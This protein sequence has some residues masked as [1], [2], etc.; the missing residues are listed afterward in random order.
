MLTPTFL[1]FELVSDLQQAFMQEIGGGDP[2][3]IPQRIEAGPPGGDQGQ[4]G[5]GGAP[6]RKL[7]P[8]N[9]PAGGAPAPWQS[10]G[11][12]RGGFGGREAAPSSGPAPWHRPAEGGGERYGGGGGYGQRTDGYG[13]GQ[14]AGG[15]APWHQRSD[16]QPQPSY[17]GYGGYQAPGYGNQKHD[18]GA[19]P[20]MGNGNAGAAPPGVPAGYPG[21]GG[22]P[23]M[24][25]D[26]YIPPPPPTGGAPP[27]PPGEY[28]PPPPSG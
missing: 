15:A 20:G 11:D 2:S 14:S 5:F 8:W 3:T 17:G 24:G 9:R 16:H 23:A 18:Y 13:G 28:L 21:Y 27:P 6:E 12:E 10:R 4:N 19:P 25:G 26:V 1:H 7:N 22:P